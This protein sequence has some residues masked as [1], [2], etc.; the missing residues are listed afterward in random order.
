MCSVNDIMLIFS[1]LGIARKYIK[2]EIK[3]TRLE[4]LN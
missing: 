2:W 1:V 3:I 4:K